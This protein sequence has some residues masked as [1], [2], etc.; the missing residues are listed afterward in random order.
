MPA[1]LI[2]DA[3]LVDCG[4]PLVAWRG[5]EL[6]SLREIDSADVVIRDGVIESIHDGSGHDRPVR[7]SDGCVIEARGRVLMPAFVDCHTHA[8]WAGSRV[9]EWERKLRGA[10]YLEILAAGGGILATVRAVRAAS[11]QALAESLLQRLQIMLRHGTTAVEVKSGYGLN[12][13]NEIKMLRAIQAA[14]EKW[15]GNVAA[16]ACIGHAIDPDTDPKQFVRQTIDE[17]LPAVTGEFPGITIDAYCEEGAWSVKDCLELFE[18]GMA[19]GHP[20]R[21]HADQFHALGMVTQAVQQHFV[22]VDHLETSTSEELQLL[23]ASE[24]Y[25]VMLPCCGFHL[26]DRYANGRAFVDAGG[27]LALATNWN[28]G[29]APCPAMPMVI[30]LACRKLGLTVAEAINAST[31]NAARVIGDRQHGTIRVGN[32]ADLI[33]LGHTD[34]RQLAQEFGANPIDLIICGREIIVNH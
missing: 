16:T 17:T 20:I 7:E 15:P 27:K 8:C 11:E 19:A 9:D 1:I 23:A 6:D 5:K 4:E 31:G 33:L 29:S 3:R 21:V 32:R 34:V 25:G 22:S 13:A 24:T 12:T 26:D 14:S 10:D 30:A 2:R 18:R 28:P